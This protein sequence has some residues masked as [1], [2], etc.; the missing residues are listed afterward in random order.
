[1]KKTLVVLTA[2]A[3]LV[4][5]MSCGG[6]GKFKSDVDSLSYAIG[7]DMG[8][9]IKF[10]TQDLELDPSMIIENINDFIANGDRESEEY[11]ME[12]EQIERFHYTKLMPYIQA[13]M[14]LENAANKDS[15]PELP[16]L[17]DEEFKREDIARYIGHS[18][19][20]N[21][22][23]SELELNMSFFNE[24]FEDAIK[25]EDELNIDGYLRLTLNEILQLFT[26]YR[27]KE[28][29]KAEEEKI[30]VYNENLEA[31]A[32]WLAEVEQMEGVKKTESGLLYRIDRVGNGAQ[33]TQDSDVVLVHYVGK[34][35]T[36]EIF[37]SSYQR[38]ESISFALNQVIKGWT[39]GMKYVR[40]GGQIT[41]WI[42]AELAYGER[43][44]GE[45][46]GPGEALEFKVELLDV[47]PRR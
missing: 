16:A 34:L 38:C 18:M 40:A 14:Q 43:G 21:I 33:P 7:V 3:A 39:E 10:G 29:A 2:F 11:A 17:Y 5:T 42:P 31:N 13:K 41:L 23:D 35:R 46:I 26:A 27:E 25:V 47:N 30:R 4:A 45:D 22:K 37:D 24:G 44:A 1:M 20:A 8:L 9:N 32:K 15:L 36:G 28:M 12:I 19:A 6:A